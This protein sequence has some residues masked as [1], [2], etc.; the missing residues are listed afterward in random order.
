MS[1]ICLHHLRDR[2]LAGEWFPRLGL[3]CPTL[4]TSRYS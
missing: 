2:V 1:E 3:N 4:L